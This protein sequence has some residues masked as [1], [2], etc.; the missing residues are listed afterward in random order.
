M[1]FVIISAA[2]YTDGP[3]IAARVAER[4][5]CPLIGRELLT[6][7]AE[8]HGLPEDRL[9]QA[10][11]EPP[12][13]RSMPA[14][15]RKACIAAIAATVAD[16]VR[17]GASVCYG[18]AAHLYVTGISHVLKVRITDSLDA[19]AGRVEDVGLSRARKRIAKLDAHR[20]RWVRALFAIDEDDPA[21]F[22]LVVDRQHATPDEAVEHI[23]EAAGARR[24]Q[25]MSYSLQQ[26]ANHALAS[27]VRALIA[28]I[29]PDAEIVA[30]DGRVTISLKA[31]SADDDR[32]AELRRRAAAA[33]GATSVEV[34][35]VEDFFAR[36]ATSMR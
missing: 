20:R 21:T 29:D 22:D 33:P 8:Q 4:L 5:G 2:P 35:L 23:V 11:D 10:I 28:D 13:W 12:G 15:E 17:D 1:P 6:A 26:A 27:R 24:Y 32:A 9:R 7:A 18:L 25:P 36:A 30:D 3:D 31:L 16:R 14:R 19:R 34:K